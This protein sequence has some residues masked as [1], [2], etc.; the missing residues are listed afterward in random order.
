LTVDV[1]AVRH[2]YGLASGWKTAHLAYQ[3]GLDNLETITVYDANPHQ[4]E[5]AKKLHRFEQLP[6]KLDVPYHHV[7]EYNVP[8]WPNEWWAD[9]HRYPVRFETIDLLSAPEFPENSL[10]WISNVFK[11][12]PLIFNLGWQRLKKHK[13]DLLNANKKSIIINV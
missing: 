5:W 10:V 12:E 4:L 6:D 3:I 13:K 1:T 11:F 9:W 7:G 2:L 8:D